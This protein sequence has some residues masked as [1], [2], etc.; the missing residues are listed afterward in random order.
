VLQRFFGL[1]A[2]INSFVRLVIRRRSQH[3]K[4]E[5]W[6]EWEPVGGDQKLL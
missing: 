2:S 3:D 4:E 5:L 1:Y 6:K